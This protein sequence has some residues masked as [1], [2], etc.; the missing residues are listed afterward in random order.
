MPAKLRREPV[1]E[2]GNLKEP[3]GRRVAADALRQRHRRL[4]PQALRG[5]SGLGPGKAPKYKESEG[6][7]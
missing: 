7:E 4:C 3:P 1:R 6:S 5:G 2:R